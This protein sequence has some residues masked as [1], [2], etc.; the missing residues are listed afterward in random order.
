M[1]V[2]ES[3]PSKEIAF[4]FSHTNGKQYYVYR[5]SGLSNVVQDIIDMPS[6][7][8]QFSYTSSLSTSFG[9]KYL[10]VE[11]EAYLLNRSGRDDSGYFAPL[12]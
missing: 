3:S 8:Y 6:G 10:G 9:Q 5:T 1:L 7:I 2:S 12:Q 4:I 11:V